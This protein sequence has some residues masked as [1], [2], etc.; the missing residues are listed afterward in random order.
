MRDLL[1]L[2]SSVGSP[3]APAH[4][5]ATM[6]GARAGG[7]SMLSRRAAL[8]TLLLAA[9]LL[10]PAVLPATA[11]DGDDPLGRLQPS[12]IRFFEFAQGR[13]PTPRFGQLLRFNYV[14][15]TASS[16][17]DRLIAFDSTY[18]REA[19][20]FIKHG[21]GQTCQGIEEA[22]HSMRVG[23]RRRVILNPALAFTADKGPIPPGA[24]G[25]DALFTAMENQAPLPT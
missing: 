18:E 21:N 13:G 8:Q 7:A 24:G 22:L 12:G 4:L 11:A 3:R 19:P 1:T 9:P 25:R 5:V 17:R 10:P 20:Y 14:G 2:F 15:Y 6:P 16:A 23:G